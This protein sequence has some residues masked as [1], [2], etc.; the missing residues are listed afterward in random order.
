MT[1]VLLV[2]HGQTAWNLEERFRGRE[3]LPLDQT[4]LAQAERTAERIARDWSPAA[5]YSSPLSRARQTAQ[6]IG[7]RCGLPVQPLAGLIDIDYGS[8]QGL[9]P[10]EAA[11][12]FPR[13][14]RQWYRGSLRV[15]PPQGEQLGAVVRRGL[16]A[17]REIASRHPD[18]TVVLIG[19]T[20][21]NRAL[22]LG[23]LGLHPS[24][25]WGLGQEPCAINVL[26]TDG[27]YFALRLLNDTCHLR[28]PE[29][30]NERR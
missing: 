11:R 19:H 27:R 16:R 14:A 29:S 30:T 18:Q 10:E 3:D 26:E 4:G 5:L 2:R 28:E 25:F 7:R 15:R 17:V 24:G 13:R 1:L 22:I 20:V 12:R 8:W 21:V 9:S 6:A 23:G